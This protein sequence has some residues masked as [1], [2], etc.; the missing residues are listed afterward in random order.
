MRIFRKSIILGCI[1][2]SAII[3][4]FSQTSNLPRITESTIVFDLIKKKKQ[5]PKMTDR[6]L[7]DFA[8]ELLA[9]KGF[10]YNLGMWELFDKN[11]PKKEFPENMKEYVINFPFEFT[12]SDKSKKWF[13][14]EAKRDLRNEC[15][16]GT[17]PAFPLT[18]ATKNQAAVISEGKSYTLKIPKEFFGLTITLVDTKTKKKALQTW[19]LPDSYGISED[20]LVGISADGK[21]IYL[22]VKD[23]YVIDY[24]NPPTVKE[25]ALELSSDGKIKFVPKSGVK[26]K[27]KVKYLSSKMNFDLGD[28][29]MRV[30]IGNKIYYFA[31]PDTSC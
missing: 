1:S 14:I 17:T 28:L 25:L 21:K 9:K 24:D 20:N 3:S 12:M 15:T 29:L 23:S 7:A 18:W 5:N 13:Q 8:N 22:S 4:L 10:N 16:D 30:N 19:L 6:Q 31:V 2:F 11:S 27:L 26:Q